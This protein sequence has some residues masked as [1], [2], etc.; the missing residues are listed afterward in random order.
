MKKPEIDFIWYL[1]EGP[2][3]ARGKK[4]EKNVGEKNKDL[5]QISNYFSL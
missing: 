1:A 4:V 2:G 5:K 3:F